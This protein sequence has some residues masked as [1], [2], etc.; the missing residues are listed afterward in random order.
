M[1]SQLWQYIDDM[2]LAH[3]DPQFLTFVFYYVIHLLQSAGFLLN[4]KSVNT[5]VQTSAW[6]GKEL[7]SAPPSIGNQ[8]ER[9]ASYLL[10]VFQVLLSP[11]SPRRLLR[12]LGLLL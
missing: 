9:V 12:I 8:I 11:Y 3:R 1:P 4:H 6:L 10:S 5:P 7:S 2:L